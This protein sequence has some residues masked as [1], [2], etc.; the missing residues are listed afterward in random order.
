M[1]AFYEAA[2]QKMLQKFPFSNRVLK[3]LVIL[4]HGKREDL[5]YSHA[6]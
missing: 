6:V 4:D 3:D 1:R 5:D 2:V